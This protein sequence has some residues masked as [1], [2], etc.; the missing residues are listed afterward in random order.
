[1]LNN[2]QEQDIKQPK[3]LKSPENQLLYWE[4]HHIKPKKKIINVGYVY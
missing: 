2:Y 3:T 1:M 4:Y